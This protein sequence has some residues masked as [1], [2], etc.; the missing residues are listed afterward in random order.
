[1]LDRDELIGLVAVVIAGTVLFM[2]GLGVL[3]AIGVL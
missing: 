3:T 2:W 1:M